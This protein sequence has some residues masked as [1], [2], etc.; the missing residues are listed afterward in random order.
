M[1]I[2]SRVRVSLL[3]QLKLK[4]ERPLP[5]EKKTEIES[6]IEGGDIERKVE[7]ELKSCV[8]HYDRFVTCIFRSDRLLSINSQRQLNITYGNN[9]RSDY[10]DYLYH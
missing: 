5:P 9:F 1:T 2:K 8:Q 4:R 10:Y 3:N 6:K 7:R